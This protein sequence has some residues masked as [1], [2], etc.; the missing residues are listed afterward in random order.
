MGISCVVVGESFSKGYQDEIGEVDEAEVD[1]D[2]E[3]LVELQNS[4]TTVMGVGNYSVPLD[5]IK[6]L[7]VRSINAFRPLSTKW[8]CFLGLAGKHEAQQA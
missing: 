3:D 1:E 2:S 5:I 7:S 6:H 4:R 8:H